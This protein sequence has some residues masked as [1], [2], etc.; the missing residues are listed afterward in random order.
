MKEYG[1]Y[2]VKDYEQCVY[3][4][5]IKEISNF[6]N[7]TPN[8]LRSYITHRKKGERTGLLK[9]RYELIEITEEGE[10]IPIKS[11]KEI[12]NE[13]IKLFG[14]VEK[15]SLKEEI[16]KFEVFDEINWI[17]KGL[18][19]K[20]MGEDEEWKKIPDFEY[21]LSNY[22]HI[23]NDKNGKLKGTRYHK[24][25]IIVDLYKDGK[26]YTMNVPRMEANLF[27]RQVLETE[28][29]GFI[30]GD[31]RNMFYKNLKIVSKQIYL[32]TINYKLIAYMKGVTM[33][34]DIKD[35]ELFIDFCRAPYNFEQESEEKSY[36]E[37]QYKI[38][39]LIKAYKELEEKW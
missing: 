24:W 27:I 9:R 26:R 14:E 17:I 7:T 23:R 3:I 16:S 20:A 32:L 1:L 35:I 21:S 39:H 18:K 22:G 11:N 6:L 10:E 28:R 5:N 34:Q 8:S 4:G 31:K 37:L 19:D 12:F 38:E 13:M 36:K 15:K 29:V 33:E 2:D 30:D 25:M